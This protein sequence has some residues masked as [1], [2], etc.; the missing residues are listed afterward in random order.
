MISKGDVIKGIREVAYKTTYA[1]EFKLVY[2]KS[3]YE[4]Q[5]SLF[6]VKKYMGFT[7][8]SVYFL[9]LRRKIEKK[10]KI[11]GPILTYVMTW[12]CLLPGIQL[13][14]SIEKPFCTR[15]GL[16]SLQQHKA[17]VYTQLNK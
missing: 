2:D 16:L 3:I 7:K 12:K 14:E 10:R 13:K 4:Y 9:N 8:T 15:K 5:S 11:N 6:L 1:E 17:Y